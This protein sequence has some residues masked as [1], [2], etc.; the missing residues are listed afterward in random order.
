[1]DAS[2]ETFKTG[3]K[4]CIESGYT[5]YEKL[6]DI[7][8]NVTNE[9]EFGYHLAPLM[10][11]W[12]K[13]TIVELNVTEEG[14]M[15]IIDNKSQEREITRFRVSNKA[16]DNLL[17]KGKHNELLKQ[18]IAEY[19]L[20][21][22]TLKILKSV[23]KNREIKPTLHRDQTI[24]NTGPKLDIHQTAAAN[25]AIEA[26]EYKRNYLLACSFKH[27]Q[28][29]LE[30]CDKDDFFGYITNEKHQAPN[31]NDAA[32]SEK[33]RKY[34]QSHRYMFFFAKQLFSAL[35]ENIYSGDTKITD[36][37][38]WARGIAIMQPFDAN[39]DTEMSKDELNNLIETMRENGI[40]EG[41]LSCC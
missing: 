13:A 7:P 21:E 20:N 19:L 16:D 8:E 12:V 41:F 28:N 6:E 35:K 1:M 11:R 36:D 25:D 37:V 17:F 40:L 3:L 33:G 4:K 29:A 31:L 32:K 2:L 9:V 30:G 10:P 24:N 18:L 5:L 26:R 38:S 34:K 15:T 39:N 23:T 22:K 27:L 14:K